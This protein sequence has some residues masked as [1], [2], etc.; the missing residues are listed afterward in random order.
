MP[1]SHIPEDIIILKDKDIKPLREK[2]HKEQDGICPICTH[3]LSVDAMALD[4]QH[5]LFKNQPLLED[6]AGL[7][8]GVICM[9]CNSWEGKVSGGFKRMGLHK[10]DI[11]MADMLRNLADYLDQ[12]NL[13]YIHPREVPKEPKIS[14]RNY[15]KI[16]S[17]YNKEEFIPTRKGQKKKAFPE[18]P[19]SG[20]LTKDLGVLFEKYEISPYN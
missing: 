16:K 3:K 1:L 17:L 19:K 6:G 13:P 11:S 9:V 5:K 8:R 2:L 18:F 14:K 15:N 4:H 10:K 20:K 7:C 12:E